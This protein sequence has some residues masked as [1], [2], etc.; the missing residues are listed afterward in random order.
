MRNYLKKKIHFI[1]PNKDY[2]YNKV[3]PY[4][5]ISYTFVRF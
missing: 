5:E 3:K 1:I 2:Y 4:L